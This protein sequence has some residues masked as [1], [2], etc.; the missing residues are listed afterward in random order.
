MNYAKKRQPYRVGG[1]IVAWDEA[2][3]PQATVGGVGCCLWAGLGTSEHVQQLCLA[4]ALGTEQQAVEH[5]HATPHGPRQC[6]IARCP[7]PWG[8]HEQ[9]VRC[10]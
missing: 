9:S 5:P 8:S 3:S 1:A 4:A 6:C 2:G 10:C 7:P